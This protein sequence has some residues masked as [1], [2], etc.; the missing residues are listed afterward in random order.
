MEQMAQV[1]TI[2]GPIF[3]LM[4]LIEWVISYYKG[5]KIAHSFD[6]ISSLSSG[7]TNIIKDVLGIA[8]IIVSYSFMYE[9]LAIIDLEAYVGEIKTLTIQNWWVFAIAF[10]LDDFAGYWGHRFEHVINIFWNRH[11]IH[12]SSEEFNLACALRQDISAIIG[13]FFFLYIPMAIVGV[14]V[15]VI[16]IVKPIQLFAQFWYHTRLIDKLGF[17]EH[18]IVTPSHH[19][20][21]HAINDEYIDKNFA[22]IFILW[23]KWFGTFQEE[24]KSIPPVYGIKKQ[25]NT[26]NPILI[27]Y[28][29]FWRL[30]KDAWRTKSWYDKFRIW[31]MPTGWRPEDVAQKYPQKTI[32]DV[33][34]MKK[35]E[36]EGSLL[37]K[38]WCWVQFSIC[39]GLTLFW[40][41]YVLLG[42]LFIMVSIFAYTT[43][44]DG[45]KMAL[46]A[47]TIKVALGVLLLFSLGS[48]FNLNEVFSG[49]TIFLIAY[50]IISL[51][52]TIYYC[53]VM[54]TNNKMVLEKVGV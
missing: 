10:V 32:K 50:L 7:V 40:F 45:R 30:I 8:V 21:H 49:A 28:Q 17:L 18:I 2:A 44:M 34:A 29:H 11:I 52:V 26:W 22:Q 48:W 43:L 13:V 27:N 9:H 16:A 39:S 53:Y 47:E 1:L 51:C 25:A 14:P 24:I 35:Y 12:H 20:V 41:G 5:M 38:F 19:R 6:T 15:L 36:T 4:V 42:G 31:F 33:Q 54:P 3:I 37:F 46:I 23:D